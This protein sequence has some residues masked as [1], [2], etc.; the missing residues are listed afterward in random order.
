MDFTIRFWYQSRAVLFFNNKFGKVLHIK[1]KFDR[2]IKR[3]TERRECEKMQ[4]KLKKLPVGEDNFRRVRQRN[5]YYVDKTGLIEKIINNGGSVNL[6]T[7]PRRFGKSLNM[8]MLRYFFEIDCDKSLFDGLYIKENTGLC[9]KYM[10]KFPV[11]FI[12][13]KGVEART[14]EEARDLLIRLVNEEARRFQFLLQSEKLTEIDKRLFEDLMNPEMKESVLVYSIRELTE[15]LRKQYGREVIVLIDEYDVPLAKANERGYYDEM[16]DL[17]RNF[18][19]NA[20]KTNDNLYFAVLTGCLRVAKE[21]IFTGMNNFKVYPLTDVNFDEY[22]GFTNQEVK[23]LVEYYDQMEHYNTIKEWYD[24]YQFGNVEVYCP[25]DV[26]CYCADHIENPEKEAENYWL[27]TSGNEIIKTFI[28]EIGSRQQPT[29]MELENLVNGGTVQKEICQELTYKELYASPGNIWSALL[30]TG[31]LTSRGKAEGKRYNLA[32]PNLE[33]RNIITDHILELFQANIEHDGETLGKFCTA[34]VEGK[35]GEV[36]KLLTQY[37]KKTISV[38]DTFARNALKE[39]FYHG[40]LLGILG[41]KEGWSVKSNQEAGEGFSD[42]MIRIDDADIGIVIEVKYA[43]EE[44]MTEECQ[45]ALK[46]IESRHYAEELE[47]EG[48]HRILKY[49]ITCNKKCCKVLLSE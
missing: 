23:A 46:Q 5:C 15:L 37:L 10:G 44:K 47:Y 7:R 14:Y 31:Y 36:E 26:I 22:F 1:G 40:I 32:I 28:E 3:R 9:E 30:M 18:F 41:F 11:I 39:N 12:S 49:G 21:S 35:A 8:S 27:N 48:I 2:I 20:L 13:L 29:K 34:L 4:E 43:Q 6:F 45:K 42:I 25:W 19:G 16:T 24:G 17:I 38:R 33:I